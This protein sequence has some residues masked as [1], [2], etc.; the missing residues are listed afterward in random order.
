MRQDYTWLEHYSWRSAPK[1]GGWFGW[2]AMSMT[3]TDV[4]GPFNTKRDMIA[5]LKLDAIDRGIIEE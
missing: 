4:V 2:Y 1:E 5:A 3:N